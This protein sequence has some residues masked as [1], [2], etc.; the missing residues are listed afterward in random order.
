MERIITLFMDES[1]AAAVEYTLLVGLIALVIIAAAQ[2]LG[3]NLIPVFQRA[4]NGLKP[5]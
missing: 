5:V 4:A 1:G 2:L 3:Q